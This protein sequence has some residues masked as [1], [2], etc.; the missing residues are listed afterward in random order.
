MQ[1]LSETLHILPWVYSIHET[2]HL[3][4]LFS[5]K[6]CSY[7]TAGRKIGIHFKINY[8]YIINIILG[9]Q[10]ACGRNRQV[11]LWPCSLRDK[12]LWW[13]FSFYALTLFLRC[14]KIFN[15]HLFY[16]LFRCHQVH[17]LTGRDLP[18][19]VRENWNNRH[20]QFKTQTYVS[21]ISA[22]TKGD[23]DF[24]VCWMTV[25]WSQQKLHLTLQ[26]R[27]LNTEIPLIGFCRH[28]LQ[29]WHRRMDPG[30]PLQEELKRWT[31][32]SMFLVCLMEVHAQQEPMNH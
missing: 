13:L 18:K 31:C 32:L 8:N 27:R 20:Q 29:A 22:V 30:V 7:M 14:K 21:K 15:L 28:L 11:P 6:F 16:F 9:S 12:V 3:R 2:C 4:P 1:I 26:C 19:T 23:L 10:M 25:I 5:S 17:S 24:Y